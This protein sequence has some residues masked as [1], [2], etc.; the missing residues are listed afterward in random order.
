MCNYVRSTDDGLD[1]NLL[2]FVFLVTYDHGPFSTMPGLR[3]RSYAQGYVLVVKA[4]IVSSCI[5]CGLFL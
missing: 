3:C 2:Q 4:P 5:G 1:R